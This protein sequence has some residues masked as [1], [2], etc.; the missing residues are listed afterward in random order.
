MVELQD[1]VHA[2]LTGLHGFGIKCLGSLAEELDGFA[3]CGVGEIDARD[4]NLVELAADRLCAA[5]GEDGLFDDGG[6]PEV[7]AANRCFP[8]LVDLRDHGSAGVVVGRIGHAH[9]G[10]IDLLHAAACGH[11]IAVETQDSLEFG[12]GFVEAA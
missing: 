8:S 3:H 10:E 6:R 12:G 2:S 9:F 7:D 4:N 1:D 5:R 11:V